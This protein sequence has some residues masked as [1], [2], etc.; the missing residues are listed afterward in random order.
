MSK[1]MLNNEY[2]CIYIQMSQTEPIADALFYNRERQDQ[3]HICAQIFI[4]YHLP[5]F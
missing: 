5:D 4:L 1:K 3:M 2:L